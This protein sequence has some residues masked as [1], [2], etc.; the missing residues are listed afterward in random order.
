MKP[1]IGITGASGFIGSHLSENLLK[2]GYRVKAL[3]K[4]N[5]NNFLGWLNDI[6]IDY[7]KKLDI[8][9]GDIRDYSICEN[10]IQGCDVVFNLAALIGIPYSYLAPESYFD[11]NVK[12]TLNLL[13]ASDSFRV[14]RFVQFS[15]SEVYGTPETIPIKETHRLNAQSPYAASKIASDQLALSFYNSFKSPIVIL[16]PFNVFGPRQSQRAVISSIIN[17]ILSCKNKKIKLG[18]LWPERDFNYVEDSVESISK[19]IELKNIEGQVINIGSGF[20]I[21][22]GDVVKIVMKLVKKNVVILEEKK[23]IRP[24]ASEVKYLLCDNQKSIDLGLYK[25]N[26]NSKNMFEIG[27]K[28]T[29]KWFKEKIKTENNDYQI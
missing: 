6:D 3:V 1:C 22:I 8:T 5:S 7:R 2:K 15:T 25:K 17:Q 19:V 23:R 16:R 10:F 11:V 14:K 29:I 9:F 24:K 20:K 21:S 18:S 4:Y 26:T 13:K 27:M 28:K 12:G